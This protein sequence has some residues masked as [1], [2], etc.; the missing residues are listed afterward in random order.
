MA[1]LTMAVQRCRPRAGLIHHADRGSQC[2]ASDYRNIPQAAAITP[3]MSRKPNCRDN[4]PMESVFGTLQTKL[5]HQREYPDRDAARRDLFASIDAYYNRRIYQ[6]ERRICTIMI[7]SGISDGRGLEEGTH[8]G[9]T[10][11]QAAHV[12]G[13]AGFERILVPWGAAA[14]HRLLE[15]VVE[16][17][18]GIVLGRVGRQI[19][20]FDQIGMVLYP[21]GNPA[22]SM[23]RQIVD[24]HEQ[25]ARG[26]ADQ[27]A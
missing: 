25:L 12:G 19:D 14:R 21:G 1:A 27:A 9:G 10:L 26:L 6:P 24:D 13:Q 5:V 2:A 17:F 23:Y 8:L 20:E 3:S 16:E 7:S 4:A 15:V 11:L 22:R 18:V